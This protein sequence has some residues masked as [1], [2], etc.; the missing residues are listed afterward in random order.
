MS[1]RAVS[2]PARG[3]P[4]LLLEGRLLDGSGAGLVISHPHPLHGGDMHHPVVQSLWEAGGAAGFSS[5]RYHFRG[6]G[7]SGGR[8]THESPLPVADLLGAIDSLGTQSVRVV[9]YSFGART[10]LHALTETEDGAGIGKAVLVGLPTRLPAN[11]SAMSNLILGRRIAGEIYKPAID[12]ERL[13]SCPCPLLVVAGGSDPLFEADK[14]RSLGIEPVVID[15]VN[16]FFSRRVGNQAPDPAD[17]EQL[18]E[19]VLGFLST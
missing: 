3:E 15:G 9:G 16:H 8:L 4:D 5:L 2:F 1:G 10:T 19:I 11:P 6:V 7:G 12:L 14:V 17:L 13:Q 18:A